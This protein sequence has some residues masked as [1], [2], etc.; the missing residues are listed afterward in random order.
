VDGK[1][2]RVHVTMSLAD[3][4]EPARRALAATLGKLAGYGP[5]TQH[6]DDAA[7]LD[8]P[9]MFDALDHAGVRLASTGFKLPGP[10]GFHAMLMTTAKL[11]SGTL[12][13]W[14]YRRHTP[15]AGLRR[16]YLEIHWRPPWTG[17][18]SIFEGKIPGFERTWAKPPEQATYEGTENDRGYHPKVSVTVT[19]CD[20]CDPVSAPSRGALAAERKKE[21]ETGA[22]DPR[23]RY[24]VV[25]ESV[26]GRRAVGRYVL[27][28]STV[29]RRTTS[30]QH[31][32]ELVLRGAK[33]QLAVFVTGEHECWTPPR[34]S[35]M[36][37]SRE[38]LARVLTRAELRAA[39][40]AVAVD[41]ASKLD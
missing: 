36:A 23:N 27:S 13:I 9:R 14:I 3:D 22:A 12:S 18:G 2:D 38:Q 24:E 41:L 28:W 32:Y 37:G 5:F 29:D 19:P 21:L 1:L 30:Y 39:G 26:G 33:R 16:H 4:D 25:E 7:A 15:P 8:A 10:S 35:P 34:C 20:P 6:D 11:P 40:L 17:A 31:R